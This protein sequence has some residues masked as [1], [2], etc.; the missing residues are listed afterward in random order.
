MG[1]ASD[2]LWSR[3]LEL[4]GHARALEEAGLDC[5]R[6]DEAYMDAL[7][8]YHEHDEP[9]IEAHTWRFSDP[10]FTQSFA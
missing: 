7:F 1:S 5:T 6:A 10:A 3:V 2:R 8:A 9:E 4:A